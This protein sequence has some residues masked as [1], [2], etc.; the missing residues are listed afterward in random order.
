MHEA[1]LAG[2]SIIMTTH[3]LG[4]A[5]RLADSVLFLL[6]GRLHEQST[7]SVFF[8]IPSTSEA[9]SFLNGDIIE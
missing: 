5:K 2:T 3:N 4:Q 7:A 8:N 6:G 1:T 9:Q